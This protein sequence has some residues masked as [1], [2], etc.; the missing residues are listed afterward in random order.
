M[1]LPATDRVGGSA[2]QEWE[3]DASRGTYERTEPLSDVLCLSLNESSDPDW[4]LVHEGSPVARFGHAAA[5]DRRNRAI[6]VFGGEDRL[7]TA[8]YL[9]DTWLYHL[10]NDTWER[11]RSHDHPEARTGHVMVPGSVNG[12][13]VLF[14]GLSSQQRLLNDTWIF[15]FT[16]RAWANVSPTTSPPV[17]AGHA[18]S[19]DAR[20][21][22]IVL[23]GGSHGNETWAYWFGNN[24]WTDMG[25]K[26]PPTQ[27]GIMACDPYRGTHLFFGGY[28]GLDWG[29]IL[30]ETWTYDLV[31]NAWTRLEPTTSPPAR[32]GSAMAYDG[33]ADGFVL[34][35][36]HSNAIIEPEMYSDTWVYRGIEG[37]WTRLT[38]ERSPPPR[39]DHVL[40][41]ADG[42]LIM[43]GGRTTTDSRPPTGRLDKF[44]TYGNT[45]TRLEPNLPVPRAGHSLVYD[46]D[47]GRSVLFGGFEEEGVPRNDTWTYDSNTSAWRRESEMDAPSP[48]GDHG[49]VYDAR[50]SVFVLF[51]GWDGERAL[52]DT[53]VYDLR[54]DT[55]TRRLPPTSPPARYGHSM[56]YD[57]VNG[58]VVM[59]GG[60]DEAGSLN[61]TWAY[62]PLKDQWARLVTGPGPPWGHSKAFTFDEREGVAVLFADATYTFNFSAC[63]WKRVESTLAP[64]G[65]PVLVYDAVAGNVM[66]HGGSRSDSRMHLWRF[67]LADCAWTEVATRTSMDLR[68]GHALAYDPVLRHIISF[69]G[70]KYPYMTAIS[71]DTWA[72]GTFDLHTSGTYVSE[73]HDC[74]GAAVFG[75]LSWGA[76]VPDMTGVRL[77]LRTGGT[78][79]E[80]TVAPF[81]GP[82]ST[83]DTF[84]NKSA[85]GPV[86]FR[87]ARIPSTH[88]GSR[89]I[90][91]KVYLSTEDPRTSPFLWSVRVDL[92]VIH[93]VTVLSPA[94][95][96]SW[97]GE[98]TI[99]WTAM[100]LDGDELAF[101]VQLLDGTDTAP[102]ATGLPHGASNLTWDTSAVPNGT[103]RV[104]VSAADHNA[105]LPLLVIAVSGEFEVRH[106]AVP[107]HP[108]VAVLLAPERDAVLPEGPV[109][110]EWSASDSD[111]DPVS[112]GVFASTE[113]FDAAS[114]PPRLTTTTASRLELADLALDAWYY[115]TVVPTDGFDDGPVPAVRRFM[116]LG[117]GQNEPPA[118]ALVNP[119]EGSVL[120]P[121][122]VT[123]LWSGSDADGDALMYF[124]L[125]SQVPPDPLDPAAV[126][127]VTHGTSHT[128]RGLANGTVLYW[129]VVPNDGKVNGTPPQAWHFH[130]VA[131]APP[132]PDNRSPRFTSAPPTDATVGVLL[133]YNVTATD[134]DGDVL[135][136]SLPMGPAGAGID[137]VTGRLAWTPEAY[138]LGEQNL[139]VTVR[140]GR[141]GAAS[142]HLTITVRE[143][144][145]RGPT[146]SIDTRR[147]VARQGEPITLSGTAIGGSAEVVYI[148]L[149]VDGGPW[150]FADGLL[151]WSVVLDS[152]WYSPGTHQ[153]E[154]RAFDGTVL[155]DPA[156][157]ELVVER[158]VTNDGMPIL[159]AILA[160]VGA[161]LVLFAA[162]S[163]LKARSKER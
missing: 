48:R 152:G 84:F 83:P 10:C 114:L 142:Q 20:N 65:R 1:L 134:E 101:D 80:L 81:L 127:V 94:G 62:L 5:Y 75:N 77:Q 122:D 155:S 149:R 11:V 161:V 50:S 7:G 70:S 2:W 49:M 60:R 21:D 23:F 29:E 52:N 156:L 106:P 124:L 100:D 144:I 61:D 22:A 135:E 57:T 66:M 74:G 36:G 120:C 123:L 116:V 46:R 117:P 99:E 67:D 150:F 32:K 98:R 105:E 148:M 130:V 145:W 53:W 139:V 103:Y 141:G 129:T 38:P 45:W 118:V 55:W 157:A 79:E 147:L 24:T 41:N 68:A 108:P 109:T 154:A 25:P 28:W 6:V 40:L 82:D 88:N 104:M 125:V 137:P 136:Y 76:M 119:I 56:A 27:L 159:W 132:P 95:G 42:D 39:Q 31:S 153:V 59:F 19:Y 92:N 143:A 16:Q 15:N 138:Q 163:L 121:G 72:L 13:V 43:Y 14:G 30:N 133:E 91:Y 140:D 131:I 37:S 54:R 4:R 146:C 58:V 3:Y 110:L 71:G 12:T 128:L 112:C 97:T 8:S 115:W 90:Q 85:D 162:S 26:H 89:W 87:R 69:G 126:A 86:S 9:D 33:E 63:A 96:E 18:A 47:V 78:L 64:T 158:P 102:L 34:F 35:G 113:R 44:D 107:N 93:T 73:P 51:G 17:G 160:I 151:N 111:G